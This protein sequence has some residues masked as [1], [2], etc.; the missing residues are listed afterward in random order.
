MSDMALFSL[1]LLAGAGLGVFYFGGLW[2]TVRRLPTAQHPALLTLASFFGRTVLT[3]L[4]F[5]LVMGGQ[6]ERL[7]ACLLGFVV[8]RIILVR[9]WGPRRQSSAPLGR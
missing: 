6:L 3:L 9:R 5:Y 4:G 1:S 8:V 7:V 2:L